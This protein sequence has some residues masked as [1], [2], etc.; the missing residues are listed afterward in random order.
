MTTQ[1]AP[2]SPRTPLPV[3]PVTVVIPAYNR[4]DMTSEAVRSV[5]RQ[6]RPVAEI[7]VVDDGS[8]DGTAE[9][10]ASLGVHVIRQKN[11][12]VSAARNAGIEA[13]SQPWIALLDSDDL[14]YQG[15]IEAQFDALD[16]HPS[17][18]MVFTDSAFFDES[19]VIEEGVFH[20]YPGYRSLGRHYLS[21]A[22]AVCDPAGLGTSLLP[23]CYIKP[24]SILARREAMVR[25][26]LF[27]PTLRHVED[28]EFL[29]R[30][31][32]G[33]ETLVI[34]RP[35]IRYRV[36]PGASSGLALGTLLGVSAVADRVFVD[37]D[38]YPA[39]AVRF[40]RAAQGRCLHEAG[41]LLMHLADFPA[42]RRALLRSVRS[43]ATPRAVLALVVALLG[44]GAY[45]SL[46]AAKRRFRLPGLSDP[47]G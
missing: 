43:T 24:S 25:S 9:A 37:P 4:R 7:I 46:L 14:W 47:A 20:R 44:P 36:H 10:A 39:G 17:A 34:E 27:D 40:F 28:R 13:A 41:L 30:F 29:L 22:V 35:L 23:M 45:H 33:I 5:Q 42:A 11:A 26:G 12:G 21:D 6:T 32:G 18:A 1:D 3:A 16:L 38:R 31:V 2:A 8:V 19:G 15:K